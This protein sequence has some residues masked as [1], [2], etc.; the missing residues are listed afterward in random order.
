MAQWNDLSWAHM[1]VDETALHQLQQ[2]R[3][4][5]MIGGANPPSALPN[6][7]NPE[8]PQNRWASDAAQ[9]AYALLRRPVRIAVHAEM[10]LPKD[11]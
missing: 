10:M 7:T 11:T 6:G 2:L 1:A 4:T 5:P 9:I 8:D 3:P